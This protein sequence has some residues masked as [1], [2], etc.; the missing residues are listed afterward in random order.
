MS[1][2]TTTER[3]EIESRTGSDGTSLST[4]PNYTKVVRLMLSAVHMSAMRED[5]DHPNN[6]RCLP[7]D[8]RSSSLFKSILSSDRST[9]CT[10]DQRRSLANRA[11]AILFLCKSAEPLLVLSREG[12]LVEA[13]SPV[14]FPR[15]HIQEMI[16]LLC[17]KIGTNAS[18]QKCST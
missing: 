15:R 12:S 17:R 3:H 1:S 10:L 11:S 2:K 4:N 16:L 8:A 6:G 18:R 5:F 14:N 13:C 9:F 7:D